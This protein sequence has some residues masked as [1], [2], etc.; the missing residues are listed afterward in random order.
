MPGGKRRRARASRKTQRTRERGA[1]FERGVKHFEDE[2][3]A[4]GKKAE[5]KGGEFRERYYDAFGVAGPI[6]SAIFSLLFLALGI[7]A[8]KFAALNSGNAALFGIYSF[9]NS[10]LGLFFLIFLF[11]SLLSYCS[12]KCPRQYLLASPFAKAFGITVFSWVFANVLLVPGIGGAGLSIAAGYVLYRLFWIFWF[13]SLVGYFVLFL[14][15]LF[16]TLNRGVCYS[17]TPSRSA[18][19]RDDG[20][21]RIYRSGE[22]RVLGGVC[23]GIAEYFGV[24]PVLVRLVWVF[25]IFAFGSGLLL[26]L[27]A[28]MIIPRNPKHKWR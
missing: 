2:V 23:G 19:I 4:L 11:S 15:L 13:F 3:T 5:E 9:F 12:R 14:R 24:D 1:D 7:W 17:S 21:K 6:I 28:W 22:N 8:L 18:Q 16:M 20:V 27:L 26:Y 10:N 25:A